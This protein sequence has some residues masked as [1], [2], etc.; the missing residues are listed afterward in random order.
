MITRVVLIQAYVFMLGCGLVMLGLFAGTDFFLQAEPS[1]ASVLLLPDSALLSIFLGTMMLGSL[2]RSVWWRLLPALGVCALCFYSL[3]HS[4]LAGGENQSVSAIS[5]FLRMRD[6]LAVIMLL[7]ALALMLRG[8]PGRWAVR[9]VAAIMLLVALLQ[10][11]GMLGLAAIPFWAGFKFSA[12]L[13]A[14]LMIGMIG[15][16][17]LGQSLLIPGTS[18]ALSRLSLALG[19]AAAFAA[20]LTWYQLSSND[21]H[22]LQANSERLLDAAEKSMT[23]HL[24]V[25]QRLLQRMGERWE[26]LGQLPQ[27]IVLEQEFNSYLRDH[28]D[29]AFIALLD[30]M[31]QP[32]FLR[33]GQGEGSLASEQFL[34]SIELA[35][36]ESNVAGP[37]D[38]ESALENRVHLAGQVGQYGLLLMPVE[39]GGDPLVLSAV[40]DL[41]TMLSSVMG[42]YLRPFVVQVE[43]VAESI[44]GLPD[45]GVFIPVRSRSLSLGRGEPWQLSILVNRKDVAGPGGALA[46]IQ[47]VFLL[48][49]GM[50]LIITQ[51][52]TTLAMQRN[53]LLRRLTGTL[54]SNMQQQ[55]ELHAFNEQMMRHS[56]D[57]LC[58]VDA[59]GRF[60]RVSQS[61]NTMLGYAPD[62]MQGRPLFEFIVTEDH[63]MSMT[64][65]DELRAGNVT[66]DFRNRY[67]HRDGHQV[68][69]MWSAAWDKAS[70]TLFCVGRDISRLVIEERFAQDQRDVLGMISASQP[71]AQTLDT[72][73]LMIEQRVPGCRASVAMVRRESA[74]MQVLSAPSL[75][76][77]YRHTVDGIVLAEGACACA[78]AAYRGE[79]IVIDD[80]GE[81]QLWA[82]YRELALA[83][84]LRSCW[85]MPMMS[86]NDVVLGTLSLYSRER[87]LPG[88]DAQVMLACTQLAALALE[89]EQDQAQLMASEQRYRSL[90]TH[91]PDAVYSFDRTGAFTSMNDVGYALTGTTPE[92]L[93]GTHFSALAD[94]RDLTDMSNSFSRSLGGEP[95]RY[96]ARV[97]SAQG[98]ILE[99]DISNLPMVV[100]GE[101]VGI[102]GIAKDLRGIKQA[103][104]ELERQLAFSQTVANSLQEGLIA[105][106]VQGRISF[107]NLAAQVLLDRQPG[108]E[109]AHLSQWAPLDPV[110]WT[111]APD[112]GVTGAFELRQGREAQHIAYK[113]V[114]LGQ[115]EGEDG[116]VI[117]LH[118]RTA[119]LKAGRALAE[120]DQ[121]FSLSLDMFCMISLKGL[122]VQ[123]NPA[124]IAALGYRIAEVVGQPY[125]DF[126]V[127]EDRSKAEVAMNKMVQ[128]QRIAGLDLR[129]RT[130]AGAVLTLELNAALGADRVIYV[131]ARDV[132]ER[133]AINKVIEQHRAMFEITGSIARIG[134]WIIDL[135]TNKVTLSDE[136]CAIHQ[137]PTGS[138][139]DLERVVD[140]YVPECHRALRSK[141]KQCMQHGEPYEL[142]CEALRGSGE[143]IWVRLM[144]KALHNNEG[145]IT[146]IQGAVQDIS[147]SVRAENELHRLAARVQNILASITDAFFSLDADWRFTYVNQQA[148]T[149]L[150]RSADEL[151]GR[152][153]WEIFPQARSSEIFPRYIEAVA[154]GHSQHFEV[155]SQGLLRWLE[156]SAYPFEDGLSVFFRDISERKQGEERLRETLAEL[157]RSNREL[158]DFAFIASHDLQEPLRKV[159]AFGERLEQRST[160]LDETGL[161]YL[162]RMRQA[163]GRMQSLIQDLL[164]YS[165]VAT[166]GGELLPVALDR[167]LDAVL[168][169][170]ETAIEHAGG[171]IQRESL[172]TIL[173]DARQLGQALQNLL[174]NALKFHHKDVAPQIRVYGEALEDGSWALCVADN[175]I[176]FDEKYLDR[177][178]NPFQRLHERQQ[179]SG[180]GIGLA[181]V[182]KIAERHQAVISARSEQGVG[183]TF[184]I[185]FRP[186]SVLASATDSTTDSGTVP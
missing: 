159:Q 50:L 14:V 74:T 5:G 3:L 35:R 164:T 178:F 58:A 105:T 28:G 72:L 60:L 64:M 17:M 29:L 186:V 148:E 24:D 85:C 37:S 49:V 22:H 109:L 133:R 73:C 13:M 47:F 106:D 38:D 112:S 42:E 123:L 179:F 162:R 75:P 79:A 174:S 180:T 87:G 155:Y 54:R 143:R 82:D 129:A 146:R 101:V 31:F 121:F 103:G 126:L 128:G 1:L 151:L 52:M 166:R 125:F 100:D 16:A 160:Q 66:R 110:R 56:L 113:A 108:N 141:L 99:L 88:V 144:G 89:R 95:V 40:V 175:G 165:R 43:R 11:A 86:Q 26:V 80:V 67:R 145:Q 131:V 23:Q 36:L 71:L 138:V 104:R 18:F 12:N 170:L 6:S 98:E 2:N 25:R 48:L 69:M 77:I 59:Q 154:T 122:F 62:E 51:R 184:R 153:I 130:A 9:L 55:A 127:P 172:A 137:L 171:I 76:A 150:E 97:H 119:E 115:T 94:S 117:T 157:E 136:V 93:L 176:G 27:E 167:V 19:L 181:I 168:L 161:D 177:I 135:H 152:E 81:S 8:R 83:E 61:A 78:T 91:N 10:F 21:I 53:R 96:E 107:A 4:W 134:G 185:T 84:G 169:D 15:L 68:D 142:R 147:D 46:A 7:P 41:R 32:V 182:R 120:R 33:Q 173:G 102:F 57:L 30:P 132:T 45:E 44:T 139:I 183:S 63:E 111:A 124:M 116:W 158:Q 65:A 149:L 156:I 90:F 20:G 34:A 39:L 114:R 163:S 118:D 140:L 92:L 70:R